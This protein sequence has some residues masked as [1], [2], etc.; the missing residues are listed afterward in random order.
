[1]AIKPY[2]TFG[3]YENMAEGLKEAARLGA[4]IS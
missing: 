2:C 3:N 1:M 4:Q